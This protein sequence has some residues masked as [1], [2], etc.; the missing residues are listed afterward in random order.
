MNI[1]EGLIDEI[2][3]DIEAQRG[4][5]TEEDIATGL[6]VSADYAQLVAR[7][8]AG[9]T[10]LDN[11]IAIVEASLRSLGAATQV[12]GAQIVNNAVGRAIPLLYRLIVGAL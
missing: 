11:E 3:Q 6:R 8:E 4:R 10:G 1:L 2:R 7:R 5:W 9:E 12:T